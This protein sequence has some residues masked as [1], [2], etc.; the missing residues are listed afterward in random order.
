[1]SRPIH[2]E[3]QK[4]GDITVVA[5]DSRLSDYGFQQVTENGEKFLKIPQ[6]TVKD[7]RNIDGCVYFHLGHV[8]D[9]VMVDLIE[10]FN[11]LK[12]E[13]GWKQ[14]QGLIVPDH[15]FKFD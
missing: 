9:A 6:K 10:K 2:F 3:Y 4:I 13:K 14:Q 11:K 15:K 1:M 7:C 8:T 5:L 12:K